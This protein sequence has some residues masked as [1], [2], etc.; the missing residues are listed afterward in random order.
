MSKATELDA[1]HKMA[2]RLDNRDNVF[3]IMKED[4]E[5]N[6]KPVPYEAVAKTMNPVNKQQEDSFIKKIKEQ[7]DLYKKLGPWTEQK[8]VVA[9]VMASARKIKA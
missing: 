7:Y 9:Q 5:D 4:F 2:T 6:G 8:N 3:R 1:Y